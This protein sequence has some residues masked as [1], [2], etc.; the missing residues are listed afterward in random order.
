[1]AQGSALQLL[2][3]PDRLMSF[4]T[5]AECQNDIHS[6]MCNKQINKLV[7]PPPPESVLEKSVHW[8]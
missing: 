7:C 2:P 5:A 4:D 6:R 3:V 8:N 1:M